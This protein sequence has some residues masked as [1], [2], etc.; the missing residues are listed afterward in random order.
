M[1]K[2][3]KRSIRLRNLWSLLLAFSAVFLMGGL[4]Q[5]TKDALK[6]QHIL[7]TIERQPQQTDGNELTAEVTEKEVNAYIAHRLAGEKNPVINRLSVNLLD[8]NQIQGK[9]SFNAE[10]LNLGRLLGEELD[11]D[12]KGVVQTRNHAARLD[13]IALTLGG[14]AVKPQVLD[15]VLSSA[16]M[17]YDTDVGRID[18]WYALPKGI[19]RIMVRKAKAIIYY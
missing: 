8:N 5:R 1:K 6:V 10:Q 12:F 9:I 2:N 17:V 14:Y 13:L 7:R 16:G 19:K 11:F 18:D 15:F 3:A 4:D